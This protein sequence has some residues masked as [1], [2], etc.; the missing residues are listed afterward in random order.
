M[1][2]LS[3]TAIFAS[4]AMVGFSTQ[5]LA[6]VDIP[7]TE[8]S[9]T[10]TFSECTENREA[11][12]VMNF[13]S[14][15]IDVG[16][17]DN[18]V[19][20]NIDG[21]LASGRID[22]PLDCGSD[23]QLLLNVNDLDAIEQQLADKCDEIFPPDPTLT[24]DLNSL[25]CPKLVSGAR[26]IVDF[27]G[28]QIPQVVTTSQTAVVSELTGNNAFFK[29]WWGGDY[30]GYIATTNTRYDGTTFDLNRPVQDYGRVLAGR[31]IWDLL[32]IGGLAFGDNDALVCGM[33]TKDYSRPYYH[34]DHLIYNNEFR[35]IFACTASING[36][37]VILDIE[38]VVKV[39]YRMDKNAE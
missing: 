10:Y 19:L 11:Y 23:G 3:K 5:T 4:L 22:L 35:N 21:N 33:G 27:V 1:I 25:V 24:L 18:A 29:S 6:D 31:T 16:T 26:D 28:G 37:T 2:K 20:L 12:V 30:E 14:G 7:P 36:E 13:A 8:F 17:T 15:T 34:A 32:A 39:E 9:G 38:P